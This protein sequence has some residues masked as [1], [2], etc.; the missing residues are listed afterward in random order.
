M[1]YDSLRIAAARGGGI[2][3]RLAALRHNERGRV[4]ASR[5]AAAQSPADCKRREIATARSEARARAAAVMASSAYAGREQQA[6]ELLLASC[7]RNAKLKT[8]TAIIAELRS[9][10]SDSERDRRQRASRQAAIDASWDR[11]IAGLNRRN[12]FEG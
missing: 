5:P 4:T 3:Q 6:A 1:A 9:R 7:D 10:C 11:A 2:S 12:G 8:S